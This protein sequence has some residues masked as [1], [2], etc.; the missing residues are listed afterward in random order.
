MSSRLEE[1]R[2]EMDALNVALVRLFFRRVKLASRIA[3]EKKKLGMPLV[4][5]EREREMARLIR[6]KFKP[7]SATAEEFLA[8]C[9]RMG[10]RQIGDP[11]RKSRL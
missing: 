3:R 5:R 6:R 2:R 8:A 11:R 1:L 9:V 4:S 7:R 10:K